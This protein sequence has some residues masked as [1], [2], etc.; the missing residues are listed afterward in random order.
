MAYRHGGDTIK[1]SSGSSF[2]KVLGDSCFLTKI[3]DFASKLM[4][5]CR[6]RSKERAH[7]FELISV[8]AQAPEMLAYRQP[9]EELTLL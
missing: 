3:D 1:A 4:F 8:S 7:R 2:R 9:T 5:W 6:N